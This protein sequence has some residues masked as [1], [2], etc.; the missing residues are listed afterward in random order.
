MCI[1]AG[2]SLGLISCAPQR[3]AEAP[4][5]LY[6]P[7]PPEKPRIKWLGAYATARDVEKRSQF[8]EALVGEDVG[9]GLAR[10]QGVAVD[11]KGNI[12]VA[13][14]TAH[15]IV[16]FDVEKAKMRFFGEGDQER[17]SIP[18]GLSIADRANMLLVASAGAKRVVAY[19]LSSGSLRFVI[20]QEEGFFKNPVG[21]AV[22]EER[23]RIYVTD[24]KL[25][26]I[27][28]FDMNGRF[29]S[30]I[31]K[32]GTLDHQV[33]SP[34]QIAV[35]REGKVYVADLFNFKVK[36]FRPDGSLV[37]VIGLGHG[38]SP[39]Y[40]SRVNG[41]AV[42]SEGHIYASDSAFG[43]VQIFDQEGRL[44]MA[45]GSPGNRAGSFRLPMHIWI[46]KND[47]IYVADT[48]NFRIQ[49]FQYLK[50]Q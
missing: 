12:Y 18:I 47:R 3:V 22:D 11:A 4:K 46:D 50:E 16:V 43:N 9:A 10:P 25:N 36:I 49:V 7:L 42:D 32:A 17:V 5:D 20:G 15:R 13:D 6:W 39:G 14:S 48:F 2:L 30:T 8:L 45:F 40:F 23:G 33:Y 1:A 28:A 29:L 31:V 34:S 38:D 37:R 44:L 21:V 41:V 26:E 19:D 35:D 24:S 27:R